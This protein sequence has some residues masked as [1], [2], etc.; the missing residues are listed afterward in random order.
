M[1]KKRGAEG[2]G[3]RNPAYIQRVCQRTV[4]EMPIS[5]T[6]SGRDLIIGERKIHLSPSE[7]SLLLALL[8]GYGHALTTKSLAA[9]LGTSPDQSTK[10]IRYIRSLRAKLAPHRLFILNLKEWGGYMLLHQP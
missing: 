1:G 9:T 7:A 3:K 6:E 10:V 8:D 5:Y 4:G 2:D